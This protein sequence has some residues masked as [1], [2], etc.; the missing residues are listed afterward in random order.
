GSRVARLSR[1]EPGED[2]H[3][4]LRGRPARVRRQRSG[5]VHL[6]PALCHPPR[7]SPTPERCVT[8]SLLVVVVRTA[9][10]FDFTNGFHASVNA[11]A[12]SISTCALRPGVA[13]GM[14][15]VGSTLG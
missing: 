3:S 8:G 4:G 13:L 5:R 15:A 11:L 12:T 1:H 2:D 10:L 6:V 14:A 9:L 7:S